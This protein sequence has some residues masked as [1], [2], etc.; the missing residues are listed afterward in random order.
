MKPNNIIRNNVAASEAS[1]FLT[2]GL[3]PSIAASDYW[4]L[5]TASQPALMCRAVDTSDGNPEHI[6]RES[7]PSSRSVYVTY[8]TIMKYPAAFLAAAKGTIAQTSTIEPDTVHFPSWNMRYYKDPGDA[9]NFAAAIAGGLKLLVSIIKYSRVSWCDP[10]WRQRRS[11]PFHCRSTLSCPP[12]IDLIHDNPH[13]VSH[14]NRPCKC[15]PP[16]C[17]HDPLHL[18]TKTF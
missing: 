7:S 6:L 18:Q 10:S 3:L 15:V 2:P 17:R 9:G 5:P 16:A 8:A 12:E 1:R 13:V 4:L 11:N 14:L